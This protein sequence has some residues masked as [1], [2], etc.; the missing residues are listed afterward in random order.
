V[1]LPALAALDAGSGCSLTLKTELESCLSCSYYGKPK[2]HRICAVSQAK[3]NV[4]KILTATY[5]RSRF[6]G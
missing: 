3:Y 5:T 4:C 1:F 6:C 2:L